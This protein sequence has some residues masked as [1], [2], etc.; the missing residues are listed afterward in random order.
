MFGELKDPIENFRDALNDVDPPDELRSYHQAMLD[1]LDYTLEAVDA[2]SKS[3]FLGAL[4]LPTQEATPQEPAGFE[5]ALLL[6][7]G[8]DL[9]P[10]FD[11]FGSDFL[12]SGGS[13]AT[14]TPPPPGSVGEAVRAGDFELT[15]NSFTDPYT[16][17]DEFL[18]P[19]AGMRWVL[20]DVSIKNVSNT[21]QDYGTFDFKLS[22]SDDFSY[23]STFVNQPRELDFGSLNPGETIRG[24]LGFEL[25]A[26]SLPDRLI[27]DPGFFGEGRI[28]IDLR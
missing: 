2:I 5:A 13:D 25:P 8:E 26:D 17:T 22:D 18:Q 21:S 1:E 23:D 9:Q 7:C 16:S 11:E 24:E 12:G 19:G 4:T 15:V 28:D 20:L 10:F 14:A 3:G 27:Y 6:E